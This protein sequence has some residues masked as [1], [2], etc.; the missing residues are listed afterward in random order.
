MIIHP[1]YKA[2]VENVRALERAL[3]NMKRHINLLIKTNK[4]DE[5]ETLTKV[6]TLIYSTW[7]EANLTK[8]IY[9][10]EGFNDSEI[11]QIKAEGKIEKKWEKAL[12]LAFRKFNQTKKNSEIPN[13]K[14]KIVSYVKKYI[15]EPSSIRNKIAHGQWT[16]ALNSEN[17]KINPT[18]TK[19][20]KELD[21]IKIFKWITI[22]S[23]IIKIV[24]DLI[25]SRKDNGNK[26]HYKDYEQLIL[27]IQ[28]FEK[29]TE[30]WNDET[31]V[32]LLK[33]TK[34]KPK[35]NKIA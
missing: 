11:E 8:L 26:A 18:L 24:E 34:P 29:K 33:R 4:D 16:I 31:K 25:K 23:Y 1:I 15:V 2:S 7:L 10:P 14:K 22:S 17:T 6:Y 21:F 9:T 19:E 20:L 13:K 30:S 5:V 27:D 28:D 32:K 3:K 35:I 12:I